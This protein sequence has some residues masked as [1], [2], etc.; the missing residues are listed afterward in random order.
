MIDPL[1]KVALPP[2]VE[3]LTKTRVIAPP[4]EELPVAV[5]DESTAALPRLPAGVEPVGLGKTHHLMLDD[6]LIESAENLTRLWHQPEKHPSNPVLLPDR[7]WEAGGYAVVCGSVLHDA[8]ENAFKIWYHS[9]NQLGRGVGY[10]VSQD[11]ANWKKPELN[12][13]PWKGKPTNLVLSQSGPTRGYAELL[14][15]VRDPNI[16]AGTQGAFKAVF[17]HIDPDKK[18]ERNAHG[19]KTA[20]S[21]DGVQWTADDKVTLPGLPGVGH[22]MRDEQ[23]GAFVLFAKGKSE[24]RRVVVRL[25][26]KDFVNWSAPVPVL[27]PDDADPEGTDIH[28]LAVHNY[29]RLYI[30]LAQVYHGPPDC[31]VDIQIAFSHDGKTWHRSDRSPFIP[32]GKEGEWDRFHH[33]VAVGK[34]IRVARRELWFFYGGRTYRHPTYEGPDKGTTW[35]GVGLAKLRVDGFASMGASFR[36]GVLVTKP[37]TLKY[38]NIYVNAYNRFGE[39]RCTVLDVEGRPLP[40]LTSQ[41][42]VGDKMEM[43]L[44]WSDPKALTPL[45]R[46]PVRLKFTLRNSRLYSVW[47]Q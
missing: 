27:G 23:T 12:V 46:K 45:L 3:P 44:Q 31:L 42:F 25:D 22:L 38:P 18:K 41:P 37:L 30:G 11:G 14:G 47:T 24:G 34:T 1:S 35:G 40:G 10:A 4:T 32:L 16:P 28:S 26:S 33:S 13:A 29:G 7:P 21:P 6:S 8:E 5:P 9:L 2:V 15:V 17:A 19:L 20:L 43:P 36:E 39:F